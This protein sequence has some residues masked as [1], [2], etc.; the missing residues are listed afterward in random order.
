MSLAPLYI[1]V[2]PQHSAP[3]QGPVPAVHCQLRAGNREMARPPQY[4]C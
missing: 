3:I 2:T 1:E 4:V